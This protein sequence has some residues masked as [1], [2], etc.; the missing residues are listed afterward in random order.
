M[1]TCLM[2]FGN[3]EGYGT[4]LEKV[5]TKKSRILSSEFIILDDNEPK[6]LS[7]GLSIITF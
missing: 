4:Y 6:G 2:E 5:K 7:K 3:N 1:K